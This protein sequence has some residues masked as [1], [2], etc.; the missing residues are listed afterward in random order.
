MNN[1]GEYIRQR[2]SALLAAGEIAA[3]IGFR[4]GTLPMTT[5]HYVARTA[6]EAK[7]LI[8]NSFCVLNPTNL[9]PALLRS[10]EPRRRPGEP[11]PKDL[12]KVG[13]AVTG[14][15]SRNL[16]IQFQENQA[17]RKRVHAIG[18]P[19]NGMVDRRQ[20]LAL[21]GEMITDATETTEDIYLT[22]GTITDLKRAEVLRPNCAACVHPQPVARIMTETM[23]GPCIHNDPAGRFAEVEAIEAQDSQAR[24]DWF[25]NEF[26]TCIRCYSCRNAC[27]LCYCPTCFVDDAK[28]QWVGKGLNSADTSIF[29]ILRAYHC[30]GRCTDCGSCEAACPMGLRMRLLTKKLDKDVVAMFGSDAGVEPFKP[31]PLATYSQ[32]DPQP[33]IVQPGQKTGED[34]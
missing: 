12:P 10:F 16:A 15:W 31:L 28:P 1:I 4:Q 21:A 7:N 13:I 26:S 18:L 5:Q 8:W 19:C 14:C 2:A 22:G 9:L 6:D 33:F 3:F 27:P 32:E 30:A 24:W 20:I 17:S 25:S 29:H 23:D 34:A 11:L